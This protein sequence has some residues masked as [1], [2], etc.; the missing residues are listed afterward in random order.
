[1][2]NEDCLM[3]FDLRGRFFEYCL[4]FLINFGLGFLDIE[5]KVFPWCKRQ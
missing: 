5:G 4:K 3:E 2:K 1:M